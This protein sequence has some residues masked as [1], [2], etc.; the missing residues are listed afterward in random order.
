MPSRGHLGDD[1]AA[2]APLPAAG[3]EFVRVPL[4]PVAE[5]IVVAR[6]QVHRAIGTDQQIVDEIC[7]GM[8]IM[9]RSKGA[10]ITWRMP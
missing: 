6:H 7:Q 9:A 4:V 1:V 5:V 3:Q 10:M 8:V 2:D